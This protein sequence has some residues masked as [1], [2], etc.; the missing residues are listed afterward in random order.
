MATF[1]VGGPKKCSGLEI[2]QYNSSKLANEL[3]EEFELVEERNEAHITPSSKEQ[4]FMY[5]RFIRQ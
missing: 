4:K 3:G 1:S 2:E 5:F